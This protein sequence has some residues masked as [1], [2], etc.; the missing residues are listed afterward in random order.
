MVQVVVGA[1]ATA[2]L[3]ASSGYQRTAILIN[4]VEAGVLHRPV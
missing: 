4:T 2:S 3:G 1:I